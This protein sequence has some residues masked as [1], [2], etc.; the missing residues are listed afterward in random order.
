M[1]LSSARLIS[2]ASTQA[3][4]SSKSEREWSGKGVR[5]WRLTKIS[6]PRPKF[7]GKR[8]S[9]VRSNRQYGFM[10]A[11]MEFFIADTL[12]K[13]VPGLREEFAKLQTEMRAKKN[14]TTTS[15]I[16]S[17]LNRYG[18]IECLEKTRIV[19]ATHPGG[20]DYIHANTVSSPFGSDR[21]ICT[22]GPLPDT[23][24]DFW[25]MV[26]EKKAM[27][28]VQLCKFL[29]MG[30]NKC[31]VYYPSGQGDVATYGDITVKCCSAKL[32]GTPGRVVQRIFSVFRGDVGKDVYHVSVE[33]WPDHGVPEADATI[34][35]VLQKVRVSTNFPIVVHCSAGIGRTG[36]IVAVEIILESI[37]LGKHV[38]IESVVSRIR[39][40]RLAAVQKDSQYLFIARLVLEYFLRVGQLSRSPQIEAFFADYTK[41]PG[42]Q[43]S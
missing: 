40:E 26:F 20:R 17:S 5:P 22:Q 15:N 39:E 13:G 4:H 9:A 33:N 42:V 6:E 10:R 41:A 37:I 1:A 34:L 8:V 21:F 31:A 29:E 7:A 11:A 3:E 25:V 16:H 30:A 32:L 27:S 35:Q 19:L 18:D 12:K 38:T 43:A 14:D 2:E 24:Y 28:I 23:I 36:T